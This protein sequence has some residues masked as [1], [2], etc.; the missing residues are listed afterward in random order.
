ME[1]LISM[2]E[3]FDS[4]TKVLDSVVLTLDSMTGSS[5]LTYPTPPLLR[6]PSVSRS[7]R[8]VAAATWA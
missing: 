5:N 3:S 4:T 7:A 1:Q 8:M 2:A 6:P